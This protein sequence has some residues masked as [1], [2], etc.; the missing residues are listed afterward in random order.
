MIAIEM[1]FLT[2]KYHATPW[3]RQV[4]E[5]AVEWP[6]SPWR[7][8]RAL[9]AVWHYKF[10]EIP[11]AQ[12]HDLMHKLSDV[13][14]YKLPPSTSGHTRH[15]MPTIN[16]AKT[17][18]FDTFIAVSPNDPLVVCWPKL[19]L[20]EDQRR[21]LAQLV[22][23]MS[24]FGRAESWVEASVSLTAP[25]S[26]NAKQLDDRGVGSCQELIRLLA[27][28]DWAQYGQW[29]A[30]I[31]NQIEK[32]KL[33]DKRAKA[34]EKGKPTDKIKL[35]ANEKAAIQRSLP[36]SAFDALHVETDQLRKAGWNRP[37]ASRWIDYVRENE[38]P[39]QRSESLIP[40]ANG[41]TIA[42]FAVAGPVRPR[43]TD[44]LWIGERARSYIMGCSKR[45]NGDQCSEAFSGKYADGT[46]R[47]DGSQ[48][49]GHAHY[50]AES[51]GPN[52]RGRITHLTIF[53]PAGIQPNDEAALS[54]FTHMHGSDGH[55]L[56]V[57]PLGVGS[58]CDFGGLDP[59][60]GQTA[61]L[62]SS[63][64]WESR[65]PFVATDHL[66]IRNHEKKD[67]QCYAEAEH[68]E[69][70]RLV[71]KELNRRPWLAEFAEG[72]T[73]E[74]TFHTFL[75]GTKTSW[76]K[77]R[78]TRQRGGGRQASTQGY[79][80]RLIFDVPV[81]GPISLGYGSHFGLGQFSA[82]AYA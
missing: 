81:E 46:P 77:F 56:Q 35:S 15:Y 62:A 14:A 82:V 58:P 79:G 80:F 70:E 1:R 71:R 65:T 22:S 69:L 39:I 19:E 78:R 48:T 11:E 7:I 8:L 64:V 72:V 55:D 43:L 41:P 13:P 20:T 42:R 5:G 47:R 26:F 34:M 66:R 10:P 54:R 25:D 6:P 17:K 44:A 67:P 37:P 31:Q 33:S 76:L 45:Q 16:D 28:D 73:I 3:G 29:R 50:F 30:Q 12:M 57:V 52:S 23:A 38:K 61:L 24:Y 36:V 68:R 4:N 40:K 9:L 74:R 51:L 75:G 27:S 18:V 21:L 59:R 32:Q 60:R 53:I 49:H 63:R 2:G